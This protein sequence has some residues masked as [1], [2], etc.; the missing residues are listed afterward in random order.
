MHVS[1]KYSLLQGEST[2]AP[3]LLAGKLDMGTFCHLKHP[4]FSPTA[5]LERS[6]AVRLKPN[7]NKFVGFGYGFQLSINAIRIGN[8]GTRA[9]LNFPFA[10][11]VPEV[12]AP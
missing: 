2:E 11:I 3:F 12:H 9:T 5:R 6:K 7:K 8:R 1:S 4:L 10:S